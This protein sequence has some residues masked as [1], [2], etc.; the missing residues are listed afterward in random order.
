MG[1]TDP[2]FHRKNVGHP[3]GDFHIVSVGKALGHQ[4]EN[5]Y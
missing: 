2:R 1:Q 3:R 4:K 5:L